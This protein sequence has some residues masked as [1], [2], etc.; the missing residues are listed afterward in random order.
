MGCLFSFFPRTKA[1][2]K[3][4]YS[5]AIPEDDGTIASQ[6]ISE[7]DNLNSSNFVSQEHYVASQEGELEQANLSPLKF[8]SQKHSVESQKGESGSLLFTCYQH[9]D[10]Q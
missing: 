10:T 3:H 1:S 6:E 9:I 4:K 5:L 2:Y 8:G 7:Q